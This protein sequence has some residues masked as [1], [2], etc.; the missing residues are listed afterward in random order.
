VV[1][2]QWSPN[3]LTLRESG[4]AFSICWQIQQFRETFDAFQQNRFERSSS[5]CRNVMMH[6]TWRNRLRRSVL[7]ERP[8]ANLNDGLS[9]PEQRKR[10][11]KK[12][13]KHRLQAAIGQVTAGDPKH[14]RRGAQTQDEVHEIAVFADDDGVRLGARCIEDLPILGVPEAKISQSARVYA[15][16][17]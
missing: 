11:G 15:E 6:C 3:G 2:H 12:F 14:L 9:T 4:N 8:I 13:S 7:C 16:G 17:C 5:P 1:T 10:L